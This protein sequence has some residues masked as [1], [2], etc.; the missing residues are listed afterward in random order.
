MDSGTSQKLD[1]VMDF[2]TSVIPP[3]QETSVVFKQE[4]PTVHSP[5]ML[6]PITRTYVRALSPSSPPQMSF[7]ERKRPETS[8][9]M[10]RT[11]SP[12]KMSINER[13][14]SETSTSAN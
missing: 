1:N 7:N 13:K 12:P 3:Q 6:S 11:L 10:V 9:S 14:Q 4:T 2:G 5:R 8:T